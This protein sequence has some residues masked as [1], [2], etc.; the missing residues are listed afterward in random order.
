MLSLTLSQ[1]FLIATVIVLFFFILDKIMNG[2]ILVLC[3]LIMLPVIMTVGEIS[4]GHQTSM[5]SLVI[6]I[7]VSPVVILTLKRIRI[8]GVNFGYFAP[9]TFDTIWYLAM[10]ALKPEVMLVWPRALGLLP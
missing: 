7:L 3:G 6:A 2:A 4:F 1:C 5:S 9:L 10:I 8:I